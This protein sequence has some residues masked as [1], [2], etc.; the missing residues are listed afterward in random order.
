MCPSD[1][2]EVVRLGGSCLIDPSTGEPGAYSLPASVSSARIP[3][4][5][6]LVSIIL[7]IQLNRVS[8]VLY[9]LGFILVMNV[10]VCWC[11]QWPEEVSDPLEQETQVVVSCLYVLGTKLCTLEEYQ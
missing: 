1:Q 6:A 2:I 3:L 9:F 7:I 8:E 5:F 4:T 10:S 11:L